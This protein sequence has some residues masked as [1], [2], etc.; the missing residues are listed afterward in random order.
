MMSKNSLQNH[1]FFPFISNL[2]SIAFIIVLII[3]GSILLSLFNKG[4]PVIA[5]L[6]LESPQVGSFLNQIVTDN[7]M[8]ENKTLST[9]AN[10][11]QA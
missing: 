5:L 4:D 11:N 8:S 9:K 6:S 1:K 7:N 3:S 2:I 10:K